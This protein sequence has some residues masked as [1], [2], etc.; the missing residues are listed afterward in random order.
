MS[1]SHLKVKRCQ[2]DYKKPQGTDDRYVEAS[3]SR[4]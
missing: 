4:A 3:L 1:P 2:V